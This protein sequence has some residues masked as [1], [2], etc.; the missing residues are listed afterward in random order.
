[1]RKLPD[2]DEYRVLED[3]EDDDAGNYSDSAY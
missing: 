2:S 3:D 1:M